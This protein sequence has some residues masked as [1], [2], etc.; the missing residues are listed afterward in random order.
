MNPEYFSNIFKNGTI[1]QHDCKMYWTGLSKDLK[2]I[3]VYKYWTFFIQ[4]NLI[5]LWYACTE[6]FINIKILQF[7]AR[8][9][10]LCKCPFF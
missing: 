5:I 1:I 2:H 6:K 8:L 3:S 4:N 9:T 10:Q 7:T